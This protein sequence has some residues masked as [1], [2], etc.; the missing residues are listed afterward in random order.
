MCSLQL[1]CFHRG[2]DL[3]ALKFHLDRV[4]PYQ[5]TI[6]GI[7]KLET[8]GYLTAKTASLYVLSF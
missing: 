1:S 7:R 4:V 5:S 6:L 2:I 3:F 8:L